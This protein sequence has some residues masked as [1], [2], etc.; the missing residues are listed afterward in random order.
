MAAKEIDRQLAAVLSVIGDVLGE[1][2]VAVY[3]YGSA[4]VGGLRPASDLDIFVVAARPTSH[5]ERAALVEGLRP[6]SRRTSRPAGWRPVELTVAVQS[7]VRPVR[8]PP[9]TDF[10]YGE[11]LATDFDA[12]RVDPKEPGNPDL[13]VLLVQVRRSSRALRGPEAHAVIDE[14]PAAELDQALLASVDGLLDDLETDTA[15]VLLTLARIWVTLTTGEFVAKD[16]AAKWAA[17]RLGAG[18]RAALDHARAIYLGE[19]DDVWPGRTATSAAAQMVE[20]IRR[21]A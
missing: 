2:V 1:N 10:Q 15:N 17:A 21:P 9:A 11:W 6:V 7:D 18:S 8:S 5:H 16:A 20:R 19:A 13:L 12:G 14:I 4:V 3:L